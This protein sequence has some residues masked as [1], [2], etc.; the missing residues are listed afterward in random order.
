MQLIFIN[1]FFAYFIGP[2]ASN[3]TYM[4]FIRELTDKMFKWGLNA[5][6]GIPN[7]RLG[8]GDWG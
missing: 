7:W 4:S 2:T 8:I 6:L 3:E 5:Q 1:L